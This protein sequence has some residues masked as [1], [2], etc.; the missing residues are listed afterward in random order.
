M[1]NLND[2][3]NDGIFDSVYAKLH[4]DAWFELSNS[5]DGQDHHL[6][7]TIQITHHGVILHIYTV[8]N[9]V[10]WMIIQTANFCSRVKKVL[11]AY[12]NWQVNQRW[13]EN[14]IEE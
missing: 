4:R 7:Y 9:T 3:S 8:Y 6:N 11:E 13:K 1:R 10:I 12:V 14:S 5:N 2:H